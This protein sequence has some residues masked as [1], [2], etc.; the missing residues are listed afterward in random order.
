MPDIKRHEVPQKEEYFMYHVTAK[1]IK[2]EKSPITLD[3]L[4]S[5]SLNKTIEKDSGLSLTKAY[6]YACFFPCRKNDIALVPLLNRTIGYALVSDC[7]R[8]QYHNYMQRIPTQQ[9]ISVIHNEYFVKEQDFLDWR[10]SQSKIRGLEAIENIDIDENLLPATEVSLIPEMIVTPTVVANIF[11]SIIN[12]IKKSSW[13]EDNINIDISSYKQLFNTYND[14]AMSDDVLVKVLQ[15]L[16]MEVMEKFKSLKYN[17]TD[18]NG[19][20]FNISWA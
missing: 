17:I 1:I 12:K 14:I 20:Q 2:S 6:H 16:K 19:T 13:T 15:I 10:I 8:Y 5:F 18:L 11:K 4:K 7:T 3:I 9:I